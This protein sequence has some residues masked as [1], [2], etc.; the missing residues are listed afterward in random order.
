MLTPLLL[1]G[2]LISPAASLQGQTWPGMTGGLPGEVANKM[3]EGSEDEERIVQ[4]QVATQHEFPFMVAVLR[5]GSLSC[6]GSLLDRRHVLTAAHCVAS[7][8]TAGL[9]VSLGDHNVNSNTEANN[10]VRKIKTIV[11]HPK[12]TFKTMDADIAVLTM[13]KDVEYSATVGPVSLGR[14]ENSTGRYATAIGWGTLYSKGPLPDRLRKVL[15]KVRSQ[16]ACRANYGRIT[17]NMLCAG[18]GRKD[19]CQGDSGGPLVLSDGGSY[20]QIGITSWGDRCGAR[21]GVYTRVAPLRDWVHAQL[22]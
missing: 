4:G 19:T 14:P 18:V 21:A 11:T 2:V 1:L 15:L 5:R 3:L 6:G 12:F 22:N 9:T 17:E 16:A 7:K 8:R 13:D 10:I 20:Y